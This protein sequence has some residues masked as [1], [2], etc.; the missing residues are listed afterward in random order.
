MNA[1]GDRES[2][3]AEGSKVYLDSAKGGA[4]VDDSRKAFFDSAVKRAV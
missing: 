1:A 4:A 3:I 2:F